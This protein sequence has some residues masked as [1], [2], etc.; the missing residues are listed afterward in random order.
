MNY[1]QTYNTT[2]NGMISRI[3]R[4]QP[5]KR[6]NDKIKIEEEKKSIDSENLETFNETIY[7][8]KLKGQERI[9]GNLTELKKITGIDFTPASLKIEKGKEVVMQNKYNVRAKK[10]FKTYP[11][12]FDGKKYHYNKT[13][14]EAMEIMDT[15]ATTFSANKD[16]KVFLALGWMISSI[17]E[18]PESK[19]LSIMPYYAKSKS[20]YYFGNLRE[21]L[22]TLDGP[23]GNI[24]SKDGISRHIAKNGSIKCHKGVIYGRKYE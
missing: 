20:R 15:Q 10:V 17:P 9:L 11:F 6:F 24:K 2:C 21:L 1:T 5:S 23:A 14:L 4:P 16:K 8:V 13:R 22:K 12:I 19:Y 7:S 3:Y 18:V